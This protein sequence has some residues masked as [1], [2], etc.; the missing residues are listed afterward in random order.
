[1]H[2]LI[3]LAIGVIVGGVA[4][5]IW[6]R[7]LEQKAVGAVLVEF[8]KVDAEARS[9]VNRLVTHLPYLKKLL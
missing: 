1:M 2:A 6:G 3:L 5:T 8:H 7:K 9:A 4:G